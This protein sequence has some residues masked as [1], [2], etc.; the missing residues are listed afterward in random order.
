MA[1]PFENEAGTY[2]IL[3]N[4]EG[5]YSLWP[6]F[7]AVPNGWRQIGQPDTRSSCLEWIERN[8]TDMRPRSLARQMDGGTTLSS[9][10]NQQ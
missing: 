10:P 4:E 5:P 6:D 2:L 1:N 9:L 7:R 8:W 3:I